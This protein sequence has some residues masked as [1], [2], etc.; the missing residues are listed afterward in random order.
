MNTKTH[1][2]DYALSKAPPAQT[3]TPPEL[4]YRP[5]RPQRYQPRI[6][7]I[8]CGGITQHHL[9]AY[10]QAGYTVVA[11]TDLQEE[12]AV[13]RRDAFY[14]EAAVEPSA[15]ALLA[16]DDIDVVDLA[17]HPKPRGALILDAIAAGKHVLSQ[18]P[19]VLDLNFGRRAA[20]AADEAGV[21]LAVNQN[22]RWAPHVAW[23]R[24][25]IEAGVIGNVVSVD[26]AVHWDHNWTADT[27][28]NDIP[29]LLL[30]DF[31]IH[32]FDM[33]HCYSRGSRPRSVFA[34]LKA[35]VSQRARPPL[36]GQVR[37]AFDHALASLVFRAD[38]RCGASDRTVV[39][40]DRGTLI[41]QGPNLG[42]QSLT[43]YTDEG[44]ANI[45]LTGTWFP[46]G[47]DGAMSELVVAIEQGREPFNS[48][49]D[50]L[51][52]LELCFAAMQSAETGAVVRPGQ[53]QEIEPHWLT[54]P[55]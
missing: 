54:Y 24:R 18:K 30:Y 19:F 3:L 23:M 5:P 1:D 35:S 17:L 36:L 48:G 49:R 11:M 6:G 41:S 29:H 34:E 44:R 28:F 10:R 33:L 21:K 39:V 9:S 50:N 45:P 4:D 25:A 53:A 43:L 26:C 8:G 16:R 42:D 51:G 55:G 20:D 46:D 38:T 31:A 22:G 2:D 37:V 52:S 47:F 32:W 27:P 13:E 14:P 7:L 40:G 15:E 12:R